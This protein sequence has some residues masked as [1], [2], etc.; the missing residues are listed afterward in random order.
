MSESISSGT[1]RRQDVI[2]EHLPPGYGSG[3]DSAL[4]EPSSSGTLASQS[5]ANLPG[6]EEESSLK[7][8]GG[9][10]H[11]DLFKLS[12]NPLAGLQRSKTFSHPVR[13]E[14]DEHDEALPPIDALQQPQGFRRQYIMSRYRRLSS[15]KIPVTRDFVEFLDLYGSFA[16]E[17]LADSDEEAID[18][19]EG[20]DPEASV[21]SGERRP[22]LGGRKPSRAARKGEASTAK[23]FF[24][25]TKAFVGTGIMF[26][27]KAFKNGGI[28]FSSVTMVVVAI[29]TMIAF[30]LLLQCRARYG[31]SYGDLGREIVGPKMRAI[32]LGSITLSQLGF[33]CAGLVFVADNWFSFFQAVSSEGHVP[34][35]KA[36]IAIQAALIVPLSFIRN[37]SKL[38]PAALLADVFI[39][40]GLIYIYQYDFTFIFSHGI[41]KS[42]ELFNPNGYTLTL[43]ASI[44]TFEGIGLILPIQQSMKKPHQFE[45]LLAIVMVLITII[46]TSVGALCYATFGSET[47]IEVINNFPQ[48][49]KIVNAVQFMYALAVLIG[50]PVQLFPA[51]R[52]IEAK[53]F[54]HHSGKKD[55]LTKWKKNAFRT[56]LVALCVGISIA[57]SE[58]LDRFV[59]LIGSV[60]CIPLVYLYPAYLHYKGC[61]TSKWAKIG[62]VTMIIVGTICMIFST[63]ITI[64]NSFV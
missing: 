63:T 53:I 37:I 23:A 25:L 32:I 26:L 64:K 46:F 47:G 54:G 57:G 2:A 19:D 61:A 17:D 58:N 10:I 24:T 11:R 22:L 20:E 34:G 49:S 1:S 45:P 40:V 56:S 5:S 39:L 14:S 60:A 9:D 36:L 51:M 55:L 27:P 42:V 30:H 16:G 41:H 7:L 38:G 44:F 13:R 4:G 29:V 6:T 8:Q 35:I 12:A 3:F 52:I 43:G 28:L 21:L 59:A 62:D 15:A 50:N 31:G 18:D 48:D 33:V